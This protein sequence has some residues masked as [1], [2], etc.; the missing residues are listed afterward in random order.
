MKMAKV[1][2]RAL[3]GLVTL[4]L[5][6]FLVV[7]V[8]AAPEYLDLTTVGDDMAP[9][10]LNGD[11]VR[12][13]ICTD[14]SLI[15]AGL[16]T[17]ENPGD[18][19]VYCA[20]A[21]VPEPR[22]MWTCGRAISKCLRD[23]QWYFKTKVDNASEPDPWEVPGYALLGVV[24]DVIHTGH[25][26]SAASTS[27]TPQT[28]ETSSQGGPDSFVFDFA[29]GILLGLVLGFVTKEVLFKVL[30][31]RPHFLSLGPVK[32]RTARGQG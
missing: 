6:L 5:V 27:E 3:K 2:A 4:V 13:K 30:A 9:A 11:T 15:K 23:G 18:I 29:I 12:V 7:S 21:I 17:S 14:G 32:G 8:G 31:T 26:P 24:V 1:S 25:A 16:L 22:S 20:G 10:I 28:T 19:I